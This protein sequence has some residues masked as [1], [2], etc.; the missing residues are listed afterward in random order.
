M[1][2]I[3]TKLLEDEELEIRRL[4]YLALKTQENFNLDKL[5]I[6]KKKPDVLFRRSGFFMLI[7]F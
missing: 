1:L 2:S 3:L 4:A 7:E 5:L 6:S